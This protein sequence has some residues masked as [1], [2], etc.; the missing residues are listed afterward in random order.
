MQISFTRTIWLDQAPGH[1]FYMCLFIGI[2][3]FGFG[4]IAGANLYGKLF[5]L[6]IAFVGYVIASVIYLP[7]IRNIP[8]SITI[9]QQGLIIDDKKYTLSEIDFMFLTFDKESNKAK[10]VLEDNKRNRVFSFGKFRLDN[11]IADLVNSG[12][13]EQIWKNEYRY[14]YQNIKKEATAEIKN[15]NII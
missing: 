8:K 1:S 3:L 2:F 13:F 10:M 15:E 6:A 4:P 9:S 12:L 5:I 14:Y 7:K 11:D